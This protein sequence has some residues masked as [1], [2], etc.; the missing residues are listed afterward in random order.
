MSSVFAGLF[1]GARNDLPEALK[2]HRTLKKRLDLRTPVQN[3]DFVAFDTELT[4]LDFKKDSIISI[5]AVKLLGS[6]I[7]PGRA[8][9]TLVR[10]ESPL[11][12]KSVVI[13]GITHTDLSDA[14]SL[15]DALVD[16]IAFIG[17]AVLIGH[18]VFID[19]NFI[20]RAMKRLFGF[21]LQN[22]VLDTSTIHD[23][24]AENDSAFAKHH[25]GMTLK[26]DLYSLAGK[27]G[28]TV[29]A[30]HDAQYD[31]YLTAQLFQRFLHF[32]PG[33]GIHT[34]EELLMIGKS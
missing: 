27:Y 28:I 14:T 30:A 18:F 2:A 20:N 24:L 8:F 10:P 11:K 1:K 15:E 26:Q 3:A 9:A 7:F 34:V 21:K 5:G 22:P 32:L 25:K 13:H 17:D 16:F 29:E 33:C 6:R 4:G 23:W 31:A 19:L 12:G